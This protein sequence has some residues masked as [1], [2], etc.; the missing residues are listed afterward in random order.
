MSPCGGFPQLHAAIANGADSVYVGL[1]SFSARA[2][3]SNFSPE[4]LAEA[5]KIAHSSNVKVY[6]A[7]NT[8]VFQNELEEVANLVQICDDVGVDGTRFFSVI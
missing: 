6:V 8:L 1:T 5:V 7:L 3:A 2:R 4:E